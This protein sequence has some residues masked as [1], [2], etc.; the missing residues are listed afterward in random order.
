MFSTLIAIM[1]FVLCV[2][3][4]AAQDPAGSWLSYATASCPDNTRVTHFEGKWDVPPN[5]AR[6]DGDIRYTPWIGAET[7]DNLN[8]IQPV[9][10]WLGANQTWRMYPEVFQWTPADTRDG[11]GTP[12]RTT[13]GHTLHGGLAFLGEDY[14]SYDVWL[15]DTATR[16]RSAMNVPVQRNGT[17]RGHPQDRHGVFK[18]YTILYVVFEHLAPCWAY[19]PSQRMVFRDLAVHCDG[20]LT[21]VT[22]TP[23]Y[24]KDACDFRA[25]AIDGNTVAMTWN[26]TMSAP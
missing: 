5:P 15:T 1:C 17:Q 22:W 21:N 12:L 18:N 10:P 19:P 24:V 2:V 6:T 14:Q 9:N 23:G 20:V 7:S 25:Q 4:V 8:V 16:A 11:I 3:C 13:A 26:T